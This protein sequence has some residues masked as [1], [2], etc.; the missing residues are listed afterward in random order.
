M[1]FLLYL[2]NC[3]KKWGK[4]QQK[5]ENFFYIFSLKRGQA[6]LDGQDSANYSILYFYS[7]LYFL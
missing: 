2:I 1:Y 4:I 6:S 5:T 3:Y 7:K